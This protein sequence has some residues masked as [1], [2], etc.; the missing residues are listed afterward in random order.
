MLE[1]ELAQIEQDL[2]HQLTRYQ[3]DK[4]RIERNLKHIRLQQQTT[5][6][7]SLIQEL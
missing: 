4:D 5:N 7:S 3:R 2:R 1:Y 6:G